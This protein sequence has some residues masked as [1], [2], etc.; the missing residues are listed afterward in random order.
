MDRNGFF[1]IE[2][3]EDGIYMQRILAVEGGRS[4]TLDDLV[5]YLDKKG[6]PYTNVVELRKAFEDAGAG[7]TVKISDGQLVPFGGWCEFESQND[8]MR[9]QMKMY[10][11]MK[12]MEDVTVDEILNDLKHLKIKYGVIKDNIDKALNEKKYFEM[13]TVAEELAPVDGYD[14]VL[15][16][17]FNTEFIAKPR[18]NEDG[19]V[20][21]H[22][23]DMINHVT[24]GDVVATITPENQGSLGINI[25][26][27]PIKPKKVLRKTFKFGRNLKPS[28]DGL[29]LITQVTGHVTLEG[30]KIFVS[31]EYEVGT[32]VDNST[33]DIDYD[34]NIRIKGN[35]LAGFKV[36]ATGNIT[37]DGVV[38]GAELNA[39][40]NIILQRGIQ[41][42]NKGILNA[43]GDIA[44]TFI[45]NS[46]VKAGGDIDTDAI[47]HSKVTARG[48][49]EVHGKNGYLMG[50]V[51]RAGSCLEAKII[52]SEMG[53][54]T[55]VGVGTDPELVVHIENLKTQ[56]LKSNQDKQKLTQIVTMLRKKQEA[57]G[58][59]DAQKTEMLQKSVKSMM[60][61]EQSIIELRNEYKSE[62]QLI[63]EDADARVKITG[64]IYPGTK[65]EIGDA[66]LFIRD[67]N[68]HC[69]YVKNGVDIERKV[70]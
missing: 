54:T 66:S 42:M 18:M 62:S 58:K 37:V 39:G 30:D 61:L 64:S 57:E 48:N 28:E 34:G 47:L 31:N 56:I 49:I 21:F 65:I 11:P 70:L 20:D 8:G 52:G 32:D 45:E 69:Q 44:A 60:L 14:A 29:Q 59:L 40:G 53:T 5:F 26:G 24:K 35:V 68:D 2:I 55:V 33:G 38:E 50:G 17:N 46:I 51:V 25:Y 23:L 16:Y 36:T 9:L 63:H 22:Q 12:D 10:P 7:K 1:Q 41:G 13:I 15:T 19:S 6:V 4:A 43:G 3:K 27:S 67:R